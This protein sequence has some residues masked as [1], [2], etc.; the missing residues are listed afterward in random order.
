MPAR[1][2]PEITVYAPKKRADS[3]VAA[4]EI[5]IGTETIMIAARI[6]DSLVQAQAARIVQGLRQ[7]FPTLG[8]GCAPGVGCEPAQSG[9]YPPSVSGDPMMGVG[10]A[11]VVNEAVQQAARTLTNSAALKTALDVAE[12]IP[13]I[14]SSVKLARAG[15]NLVTGVD[16]GDPSAIA[17]YQ[18]ILANAKAG[19]TSA[20]R[21]LEQIDV[22]RKASGAV[23]AAL[24]G[25]PAALA[26]LARIDLDARKGIQPA[27]DAK[28]AVEA[29]RDALM[30]DL[31]DGFLDTSHHDSHGAGVLGDLNAL[32]MLRGIGAMPDQTKFVSD[33]WVI[34][35]LG[36]PTN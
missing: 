36:R 15:A 19:D 17:I 23:K 34:S 29:A 2:A 35:Q 25:Q 8:V 26:D 27:I 9:C 12:F 1:M 14:G 5:K 4:A 28:Y 22:S 10:A 21:V 24:A 6:P 32:S 18:T 3:W 30:P 7:G 33:S 31:R 11:E 20:V 13:G 16:R